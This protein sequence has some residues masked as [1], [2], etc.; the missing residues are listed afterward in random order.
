MMYSVSLRYLLLHAGVGLVLC[1]VRMSVLHP[2]AENHCRYCSIW[3]LLHQVAP[4]VHVDRFELGDDLRKELVVDA[5]GQRFDLL[6]V[7]TV[8]GAEGT[9]AVPSQLVRRVHDD[10]ID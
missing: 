9:A 1:H 5:V 6:A 2:L 8:G 7:G 3:A 4:D 10:Q